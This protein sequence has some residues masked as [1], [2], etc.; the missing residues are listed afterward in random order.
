LEEDRNDSTLVDPN[1][2][3]GGLSHVKVLKGRVAPSSI[4][5]WQGVVRRTEVGGSNCDGDS[6]P[7]PLRIR[8]IVT[9]D[10]V[11]LPT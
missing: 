3:P 2:F 10:L 11:A 6:L 9:N 8:V 5:V 7:T 1:F 4:V